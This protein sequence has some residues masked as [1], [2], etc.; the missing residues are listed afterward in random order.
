[1]DLTNSPTICALGSIVRLPMRMRWPSRKRSASSSLIAVWDRSIAGC[2]LMRNPPRS[3]EPHVGQREAVAGGIGRVGAVLED[4][5]EAR[6]P[7]DRGDEAR[8]AARDDLGGERAASA[9]GLL[10]ALG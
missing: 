10:P 5:G 2:V 7:V 6:L 9:Q 8:P 3:G 4:A 1:M